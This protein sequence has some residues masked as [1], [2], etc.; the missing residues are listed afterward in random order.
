MSDMSV[1]VI[2][3]SQVSSS[4]DLQ[5]GALSLPVINNTSA[6]PSSNAPSVV[7]ILNA[8]NVTQLEDI[9]GET[10]IDYMHNT[11]PHD[12]RPRTF[13][14]L[15]F[16]YKSFKPGAFYEPLIFNGDTFIDLKFNNHYVTSRMEMNNCLI[17]A[18]KHKLL[19]AGMVLKNTS[20]DGT[21]ID[22]LYQGERGVFRCCEFSYAT[23]VN[24]KL[25]NLVIFD[26]GS[27]LMDGVDFSN[28]ELQNVKI[29]GG[30]QYD[31]GLEDI[32]FRK[33][34]ATDFT[35]DNVDCRRNVDFT[36]INIDKFSPSGRCN[37]SGINFGDY[38]LGS[39]TIN[40][41]MFASLRD[42]DLYLDSINNTESGALFF[43]ILATLKNNVVRCDFAEQLVAMLN[44]DSLLAETYRNSTSLKLS[45]IKEMSNNCY[46][47]STIIKDFFDREL[48]N[49]SKNAL[50]SDSPH[51]DLS[52]LF[53][54]LKEE[55]LLNYQFPINQLIKSNSELRDKFYRQTPIKDFVSYIE[56]EMMLEDPD[57]PHQIFYNP[58]NKTAL[59]LPAEDFI[60][61]L[62]ASQTPERYALLRYQPDEE[63]TVADMPA[64][65]TNISSVLE[66][67]PKLHSLWSRS[68]GIMTPVIRFL[69]SHS[70]GLESLQ[71]DRATEIENHMVSLLMRKVD[72]STKLIT[73]AD[74]S[75]LCEILEPFYRAETDEDRNKAKALRWQ[76][77]E[78]A[79]HR[80]ALSR[81]TFSDDEQKIIAGMIIIRMLADLFSTR[82]YAEEEDSANAPRQLARDLI[83]DIQQFRPDMINPVNANEWKE[84]LMP[85]SGSTYT[86]S[87]IVAEMVASY[88][89]P[90]EYGA[91]MNKAIRLH[92]PLT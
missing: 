22:G 6:L 71:K 60:G 86:C 12:Q 87:A 27:Q 64:G 76:L 82:F 17:K 51:V 40:P 72:T 5:P 30:F 52:E 24:C 63:K 77:I 83:D 31:Y 62:Y 59:Y 80:L 88:K 2:P 14:D 56:N 92:Y 42:I 49:H 46:A 13:R 79:Q 78:V 61:L 4:E 11:R 10:F 35:L 90:G 74:E 54:K 84:R 55:E 18:E 25:K 23:M 32:S 57:A 26:D 91:E 34:K 20:M 73:A 43:K 9:T 66:V 37:L 19:W 41:D 44:G 53:M 8:D 48:L 28:S 33:V 29:S 36:D 1:N 50:L 75:L 21:I 7:N 16:G 89:I 39:I 58:D 38:R 69:F 81:K 47:G 70:S 67:F 15:G 68:G 45:F 3:S 85:Q 65:L